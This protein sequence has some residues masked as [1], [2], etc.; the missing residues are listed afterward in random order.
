MPLNVNFAVTHA[1]ASLKTYRVGAG[2]G[3]VGSAVGLGVGIRV[4]E[5]VGIRVG[6]AVGACVIK[7]APPQSLQS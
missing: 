2:V 4:G 3:A 5:G 6:V 1:V 7:R